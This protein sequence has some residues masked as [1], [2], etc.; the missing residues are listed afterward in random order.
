[1]FVLVEE[2]VAVEAEGKRG[3][4]P[5]GN[6]GDD[7]DLIESAQLAVAAG[8][9]L[10]VAES[11]QRTVGKSGRTRAAA[12][13]RKYDEILATSRIVGWALEA[14]LRRGIVVLDGRVDRA[15][16]APGKN[17]GGNRDHQFHRAEPDTREAGMHSLYEVLSAGYFPPGA[18]PIQ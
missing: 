6:P 11:L 2:L 4:A 15:R 18:A 9:E 1:L 3:E 17:Q 8:G 16:R 14:V 13:E 7:I 10:H 12:G 5:A